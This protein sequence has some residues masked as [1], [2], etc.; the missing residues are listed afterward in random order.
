MPMLTQKTLLLA[1]IETTS[2]VDASPSPTVDALLV[3][4]PTFSVKTNFVERQVTKPDLS[5]YASIPG[6][7]VATVGFTVEVRGSGTVAKAPAW[8]S[9]LLPACGMVETD[10]AAGSSGSNP[11]EAIFNPTSDS[12]AAPMKTATLY[13]YYD[14][15]LQKV[16]GAMGTWSLT[17]QAG[18][19]AKMQ[20]TFTGVYAGTSDVALPASAFTFTDPVPPIVQSALLVYGT[21]TDLIVDT[22]KLDI[23]NQVQERTDVNAVQGLHGVRI[24]DRTPTGSFDPEAVTEADHPFWGDMANGTL[25]PLTLQIGATPGNEVIFAAPKVQITGMAYQDRKGI[26]A[27]TATLSPRRN[28]GNDELSITFI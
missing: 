27:Y 26:R 11:A 8:A 14:G 2:N 7:K 4:Q 3:Y 18:G 28:S 15:A 9:A 10:A 24:T 21:N 22:F 6:S 13:I 16:T 17:G 1:K 20:F 19:V 12:A 23:G 5:P 25:N